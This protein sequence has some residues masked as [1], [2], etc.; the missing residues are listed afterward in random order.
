MIPAQYDLIIKEGSDFVKQFI[1]KDSV[2]LNPINIT[3]YTAAAQVRLSIGD[4]KPLII[5]V[6]V[7]GGSNGTITISASKAVLSKL[8][9]NFKKQRGFW[10]L[11]VTDTSGLTSCYMQGEVLLLPA[12]TR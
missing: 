6:T 12:V 10:D 1:I 4:I 3:G 2:L 5:F 9:L 8:P 7:I 11:M